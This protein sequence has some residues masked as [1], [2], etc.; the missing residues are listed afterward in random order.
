M[1]LELDLHKPKVQKA[2]GMVADVG[3]STIVIGKTTVADSIKATSIE[4]MYALLS[5]PYLPNPSEMI[6]SKQM[7]E[8]VDYSKQ[9][10]DYVVID[11]PPVGLI[12]DA[13]VLMQYSDITCLSL[14]RNLQTRKLFK[15]RMIL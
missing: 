12:S 2:L 13:I 4:N 15:M 1:I 3:I 9:N 6:L 8:I 7:E 11:T 5:G 10:F 14:I